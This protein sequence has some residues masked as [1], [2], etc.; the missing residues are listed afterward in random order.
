MQ[1]LSVLK[2][3]TMP[4]K[5]K[6]E[7]H[8]AEKH[9]KVLSWLKLELNLTDAEPMG[10]S[11][12]KTDILGRHGPH[13]VRFSLKYPSGRNCQVWLPTLK[14]LVEQV[15]YLK[16]VY[17]HLMKW[18]GTNDNH[19]FEEWVRLEKLSVNANEKRRQRLGSDKV[20]GFHQVLNC[21]DLATRDGS[22]LRPM[23]RARGDEP[24]VDHIV[25]LNK[26]KPGIE[27]VDADKFQQ[28][29]QKHGTWCNSPDRKGQHYN[30]WCMVEGR[31]IFH[32]Q[33]KGSGLNNYHAPMFH[34]HNNWPKS[35][36]IASDPTFKL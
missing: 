20:L 12:T 4:A 11:N 34:I 28:W 24:P 25:W 5:E 13:E 2:G 27:V 14:S 33:M 10:Q 29:I 18:L 6:H 1:I 3:A 22:L 31:K 19:L 26:G 32:L 15:P 17:T 7:G 36:V 9:D 35:M 16:P 8:W 30:I 21:F 23:L